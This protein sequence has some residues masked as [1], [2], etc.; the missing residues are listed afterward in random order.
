MYK[1]YDY[2]TK[3]FFQ[4]KDFYKHNYLNDVIDTLCDK[5]SIRLG[6]NG[7][8]V[9]YI[10]KSIQPELSK[11]LNAVNS[12]D[13]F[14]NICEKYGIPTWN[15]I[16]KGDFSGYGGGIASG[17]KGNAFEI[18]FI[19]NFNNYS[20]EFGKLLNMDKSELT[21]A[22]LEHVGKNN[23]RR[24][25]NITKHNIQ[26]G[27][28]PKY[29]GD[30][31]VDVKCI[32]NKHNYNLSLKKDDK[33]TF[34]NIGIGKYIKNSSFNNYQENEIYYPGT[35]QGQLLLDL[36]GIDNNKF[37]NT[38][39]NYKGYNGGR[40]TKAVTENYDVTEYAKKP[41]FLNFIKSVIGYNYIL[42]H[43]IKNDVH[44]YDLR[45]EKDLDNFIGQILSMIVYYP[46][47]GNK[48][49]VDIILETTTLKII[50]NFRNKGG[51]II[52]NQL[53]SDYIIK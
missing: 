11:E 6:K 50:F 30:E 39:I 22:Y 16:F 52:P 4:T 45:T 53:M 37:A 12:L 35:E 10:N 23:T 36:F 7:E 40:K 38:F 13:E 17:N 29:V 51:G 46:I 43:Q 42:V 31:V 32:T 25:I 18:Q 44:F 48:K 15:K 2:L 24:P 8:D 47:D 14:N 34:C 41:I 33:V 3:M 28:G 20:D 19:K 21:S 1:L 5:D 27:N 26:I 9:Y 49:A